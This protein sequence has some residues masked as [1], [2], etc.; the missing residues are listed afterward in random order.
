[1]TALRGAF[2]DLRFTLEDLVAEGDRVAARYYWEGTQEGEF[3]GYRPTGQAVRV[4]GMDFYRLRDGKI[5][6]HWDRVDELGLLR[7][8]GMMPA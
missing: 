5:V 8:L 2:P 1:L 7:Q 3:M 4:G 6:E